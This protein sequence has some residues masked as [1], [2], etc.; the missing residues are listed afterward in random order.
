MRDVSEVE[1][2][3]PVTIRDGEN[4]KVAAGTWI[5][6]IG[7]RAFIDTAY[8]V[9]RVPLNDPIFTIEDDDTQVIGVVEDDPVLET[10]PPELE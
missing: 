8:G 9:Y 6:A 4:R 3:E 1:Y 7:S 5:G 10:I 2:A